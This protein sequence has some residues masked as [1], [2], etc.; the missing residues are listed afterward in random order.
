MKNKLFLFIRKNIFSLLY[1]NSSFSVIFIFILLY[2]LSSAK[3]SVDFL[4]ISSLIVVITKIFSSNI[5]NIAV[6]DKNVS[7]IKYHFKFRLFISL[8]IIT[9]FFVTKKY[10]IDYEDSTLYFCIIIFILSFWIY[11]LRIAFNEIKKIKNDSFLAL[12]SVFF[13]YLIFLILLYLINDRIALLIFLILTSLKNILFSSFFFIRDKNF[14]EKKEKYTNEKYIQFT[15][16]AFF[17]FLFLTLAIFILR[18]F[19]NKEFD[20]DFVSDVLFSIAISNLPAS[21]INTTF[22]SSYLNRDV[23]LPIFFKYLFKFYVLLL[24]ISIF[25]LITNFYPS[26]KN[27]LKILSYSLIGG[28]FMFFAEIIRILNLAILR[29]RRSVFFRDIIF[30]LIIFLD[31]FLCFFFKKVYLLYFSY[32]FFAIIIY[33]F[34]Y[35]LDAF[36]KKL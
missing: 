33:C 11:E 23:S 5:K 4:I 34:Y 32:S 12:Y 14:E 3:Y 8:L 13:L 24:L 36:N 20:D 19:L 17:S 27:F 31:L 7:L 28:F 25:F 16:L 26:H 15:N 6:I 21:L 18:F 29:N 35:K 9:F 30:S 22:G 10:F 2:F 1:L